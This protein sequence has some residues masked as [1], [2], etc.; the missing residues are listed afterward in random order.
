MAEEKKFGTT[1]TEDV[2]AYADALLTELKAKKKED[3]KIDSGDIVAVLA[4][5]ATDAVKAAWGMGEVK[6]ELSE[7]SDDE[8]KR[9]FSLSMPVLMKLVKLFQP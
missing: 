6:D 5:T 2:I 7:L 8:R 3:G 9:L 4:S 1:E